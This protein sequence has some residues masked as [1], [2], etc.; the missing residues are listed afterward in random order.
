MTLRLLPIRNSYQRTPPPPAEESTLTVGEVSQFLRAGGH[1]SFFLEGDN[2]R[3]AVNEANV[4]S[5]ELQISSKLMR[6]A[7]VDR[8]GGAAP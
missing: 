7:R 3:F 5:T 8:S 2:V 6:I 4:A 1:I